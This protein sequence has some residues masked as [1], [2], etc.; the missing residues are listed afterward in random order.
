MPEQFK[1]FEW[2]VSN[3]DIF[4]LEDLIM[5]HTRANSVNSSGLTGKDIKD[6][7]K[8]YSVRS[9][10]C[11]D[12][13]TVNFSVAAE[14]TDDGFLICVKNISSTKSNRRF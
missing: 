9:Y 5:T 6:L 1:D 4:S 7:K 10:I 13:S 3:F 2:S 11:T 12:I 8:G 14:K